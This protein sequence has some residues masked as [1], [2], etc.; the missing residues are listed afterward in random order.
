MN[1]RVWVGAIF[2]FLINLAINWRIAL[3]GVSPYR[4]SIERGYA[5]MARLFA[6]NPDYLS[7]N[8]LQYG[9][10]PMHYVYLPLLPYFNALF[11]WADPSLDATYV[12][13]AVCAIA[14]FLSPAAAFLLI[15]DWTGRAWPA[16]YS[17]LAVTLYSPL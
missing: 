8:P 15:R 11:L 1:P 6:D 3:P 5:Y 12:H 13:R 4:G 2:V 9:G 7:W 10:I 16:F 17:A 14:L